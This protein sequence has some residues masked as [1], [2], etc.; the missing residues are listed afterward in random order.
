[1]LQIIIEMVK[2]LIFLLF[3]EQ[4]TLCGIIAIAFKANDLRKIKRRAIKPRRTCAKSSTRTFWA[5]LSIRRWVSFGSIIAFSRTSSE[6]NCGT[7]KDWQM[8]WV[9]LV[10]L[11]VGARQGV[12]ERCLSF[13]NWFFVLND[14]NYLTVHLVFRLCFLIW[15]RE[16]Y[17]ADCVKRQLN[18]WADDFNRWARGENIIGNT[19]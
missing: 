10:L 5:N 18:S 3:Y 4:M 19:G 7:P 2:W 11:G 6:I 9:Q 13:H 8:V 16:K 17:R 14:W 12:G 15:E 1:M